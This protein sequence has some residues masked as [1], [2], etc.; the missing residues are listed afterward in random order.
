[1]SRSQVNVRLSS[2]ELGALDQVPGGNRGEK[3]RTL[4]QWRMEHQERMERIDKLDAK[5]GRLVEVLNERVQVV[6]LAPKAPSR[7][8]GA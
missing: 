2:Q 8:P 3:I 7:R 5:L 6:R 1:M 4:L